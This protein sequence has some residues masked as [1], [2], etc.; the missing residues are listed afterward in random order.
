MTD[1]NGLHHSRPDIVD[2]ICESDAITAR[3]LTWSAW[4]TSVATA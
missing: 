3:S 4:G 1:C 2:V